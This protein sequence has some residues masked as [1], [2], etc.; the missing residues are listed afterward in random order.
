MQIHGKTHVINNIKKI[1]GYQHQVIRVA[2]KS[3]PNPII[4][5]GITF[6]IKLKF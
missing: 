2:I 5:V 6:I 3:D 1:Y 4:K